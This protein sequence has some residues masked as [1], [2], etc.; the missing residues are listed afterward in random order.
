MQN[1]ARVGE[2][3]RRVM[4]FERLLKV[5]FN[6]HYGTGLYS[7]NI[8][9]LNIVLDDLEQFRGLQVLKAL[10]FEMFNVHMKRACRTTYHFQSLDIVN[11]VGAMDS[12]SK[13]ALKSTD[14]IC[15]VHSLWS[16]ER[17]NI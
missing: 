2:L 3:R 16:L 12:R 11:I 5:L 1:D 14:G 4:D 7:I 9:P 13:E 10:P 15:N 17:A 6:E 8:Q